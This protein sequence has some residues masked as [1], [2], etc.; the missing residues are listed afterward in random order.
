VRLPTVP[1]ASRDLSLVLPNGVTVA[2]VGALVRETAGELLESLRVI[3][4]Y[5][6]KGVPEGRRGVALGLVFRSPDRTLR[7]AEVDALVQ[8]I[9]TALGRALDVTVRTA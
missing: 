8:R 3:D 6:G 4:E 7:D 2:A 5:R 9:I 1:A